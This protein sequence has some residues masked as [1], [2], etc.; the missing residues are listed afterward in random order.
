[1]SKIAAIAWREFKQ[2]VMRKIFLLAVLGM[3]VLVIA[4]AVIAGVMMKAHGEGHDV[5]RA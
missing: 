3:P 2:T 4:I 1:M 5:S